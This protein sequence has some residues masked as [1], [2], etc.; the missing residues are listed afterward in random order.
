[1]IAQSK[2]RISVSHMTKIAMMGVLAFIIMQLSAPIPIFPAFLKLDVSDLPALIAAFAMGPLAGVLVSAIKNILHLLQ[3]TTGGVGELA[4]FFI[5]S[6]I[7]IPAA[8]IYRRH[9][10]KQSAIIG[11]IVGTITMAIAGGIANYFVL[12]PFYSK[13]MPV[14]III[15]MGAV[16][17]PNISNFETLVLYGIIPFNLVKGAVLS[18]ITLLIYKHIS[19]ILHKG[20]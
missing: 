16:V 20:Q 11:L 19:P 12:L 6:A 7:T 13:I 3:T 9:K 10:T 14:D 2:K 1:M 18:V 5:A 4:N 17:N 8:L 15:N